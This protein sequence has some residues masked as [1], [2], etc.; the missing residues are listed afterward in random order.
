L[1]P[2]KAHHVQAT[3]ARYVSPNAASG[4]LRW[5]T[6]ELALDMERL[7]PDDMPRLID[8]IVSG[9]DP[10]LSKHAR[11]QLRSE[12]IGSSA[13]GASPAVRV[14]LIQVEADVSEARLGAR[15]MCQQAGGTSLACQRVATGVSELA[16]NV[17]RYAGGGQIEVSVRSNP[18]GIAVRAVDRG[19]GIAD[20]ESVL[21]GT[22]KSTTGM[23]RGLA[24][25]RNMSERFDV[26]TG[27]TGTVVEFEVWI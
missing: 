16:R 15:D 14:Y 10:F 7:R 13:S 2:V 17:L 4:I 19:G 6:R 23:G 3:L 18:K 21:G 24:G 5:A 12:L 25:V 20:L 27:P 9:A 1:A 26:K 22:Y 11:T 8:A